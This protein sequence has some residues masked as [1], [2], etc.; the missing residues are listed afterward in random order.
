MKE[1]IKN[2][3]II[4]AGHIGIA[5][6]EGLLGLKG[7]RASNLIVASPSVAK[8]QELKKL[9]LTLTGNNK[10]AVRKADMVFLAVKP[11]V[12]EEV[13]MEIKDAA[14]DKIIVSLAA[15]VTVDRLRKAAG[16]SAQIARIMPNIPI[17]VN[18]GVIGF[19]GGNTSA[20]EKASL[21]KILFG[22]G[23]VIEID[24]E[25][26]FD[27][28]T[29]V[30]GCGPGIAAYLLDSLA[31]SALA[32]GMSGEKASK[33]VLQTFAGTLAYLKKSGKTPAELIKEVATKGGVTEAILSAL[34]G[35]GTRKSFSLA[36]RE[37]KTRISHLKKRT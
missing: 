8:K 1:K 30:S 4:G 35:S 2:I 17:A 24:T 5:L 12:V 18:Q 13:V 7:M 16:A 21:K 29:V 27:A 33:V 28:L 19:F 36:L 15:G 32:L 14:K 9:G 34:E 6:A 10:E 3:A 26:D 23:L 20:F 31:K 25:S 37:G 22:L 11:S